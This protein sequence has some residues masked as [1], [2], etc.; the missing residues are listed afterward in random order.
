MSL[1]GLSI[2]FIELAVTTYTRHVPAMLALA[3]ELLLD[4]MRFGAIGL[5][6]NGV[7]L[8]LTVVVWTFREMVF[9]PVASAYCPTLPRSISALGI[10][11]RIPSHSVSA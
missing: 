3:V 1:N 9:S 5:A 6:T 7:A 11:P 2:I 10:R 4:G 8:A